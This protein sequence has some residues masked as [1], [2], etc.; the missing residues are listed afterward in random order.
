MKNTFKI[1]TVFSYLLITAFVSAQ[2]DDKG[3][4]IAQEAE[5]ADNGWNSAEMELTMTLKNKSGQKTTRK[6]RSIML[7]VEND[8]DKSLVVFDNPTD[9]KGTAS[10]VYTHK[11]KDDD[12]WLYLP[13]LKQIK[14]IS[15]RNKSG[16]FMGSEFAFEDMASQEIEKY[17]HKF[18]EESIANEEEC[19]LVERY[20]VDKNS[21]YKRQQ[22][23]FN[24]ANYRIEKIDY[25]DRKDQLIKTLIYSGYKSYK[26]NFWRANKMVM[27]NHRTGKE[28]VIDYLFHKL[29]IGLT[30][31]NFSQNSLK[32]VK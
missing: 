31:D 24:K 9:V 4:Q 19:Y 2:S 27:V 22:V 14:R 7:E 17:D 8:G 6:L 23:W 25:Y 32:N 21:G 28:T 11:T 1:F 13:A 29:D 16:P 10:L 5:K 20:P 30:D 3:F 12:Q 18:I 15:S 26:V